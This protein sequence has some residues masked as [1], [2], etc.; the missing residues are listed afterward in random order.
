MHLPEEHFGSASVV[1]N[2]LYKY[3]NNS[4]WQ[5]TQKDYYIQAFSY[6]MSELYFFIETKII[7]LT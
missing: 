5:L 2:V 4:A 6:F 3:K 1:L 7:H